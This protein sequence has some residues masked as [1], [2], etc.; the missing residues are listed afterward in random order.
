MSRLPDCAYVEDIRPA[1]S[2]EVVSK[3]VHGVFRILRGRIRGLGKVNFFRDRVVRSEVI[4]RTCSDVEDSVTVEI[5]SGSGPRVVE[6][7]DVLHAE[8]TGYMLERKHLAIQVLVLDVLEAHFA[9]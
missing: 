6:V 1:I 5:G 7:V 2:S 4:I 9:A 8:V 3:I